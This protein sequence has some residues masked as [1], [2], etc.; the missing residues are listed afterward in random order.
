V[1]TSPVIR[2]V[3]LLENIL[4]ARPAPPP[5]NTP[6][7]E[8][9]IRGA[10]TIRDQLQ[11]H[12]EAASCRTCHKHIDPP[13]FALENFDAIGR[14]RG[15]YVTA[16][17]AVPVDASGQFG[18][19]KFKDV[20]GFKTELLNRGEQFARCLVEK[21]LIDALGRELDVAD[22]PHIRKIVETAAK[23]GYRLRDL[24]LLCAES[25]LFRRK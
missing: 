19:T 21:L 16:N 9:D 17:V 20:A 22:R 11:K 2:G 4:G 1:D 24:V 6:I 15:H 14:W 3:W 12:R 10:K 18:A 13:G 25:D 7:L 5:P 23:D 8:P